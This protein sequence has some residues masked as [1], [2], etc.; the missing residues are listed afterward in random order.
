[1]PPADSTRP[2]A[3]AVETSGRWGSVA[4]GRD[5]TVLAVRSLP[6]PLQHAQTFLATVATLCRE[7]DVPPERIGAVFL[8]IGPGSFTGLRVG[9]AAA[10]MFALVH[11][12][13][14]VPVPTLSVI[15][16]NALRM[17]DPPRH[18][19]VMLDAKRSNVYAD[20]FA[21]Q[22][23][24]PPRY[25]SLAGPV[26]CDPVTFW[27][28]HAESESVAVMGEGA[29]RHRDRLASAGAVFLPDYLY[30]PSAELVYLLGRR[31]A[32]EGQSVDRRNLVPCYVRPPEAEEK[33]AAR[34][35]PRSV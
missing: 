26:E 16:Q 28:E 24:Q 15:A 23:A 12:V 9:V 29:S 17:D 32:L 20:A 30:R 1:M 3:L 33:W 27:R 35:Q 6:H 14:L 7:F 10:R 19:L 8:S 22:D 18:V 31:L 34:H 5:E 11:P 13:T 4:L 21:L 2:Y 25:E